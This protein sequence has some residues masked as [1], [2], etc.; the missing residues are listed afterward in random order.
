MK[1]PPLDELLGSNIK[2]FRLQK[3]LTQAE[4][5]IAID[6]T[7]QYVSRVE[8]CQ[9]WPGYDN[10]LKIASALEVDPIDLF[11]VP[12]EHRPGK[13]DDLVDKF[14]EIV[15]TKVKSKL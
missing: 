1:K 3:G 8:N 13:F 7:M 6:T 5:S 9:N 14:A 10:I 2:R 11:Q 15:A 12:N 4:L